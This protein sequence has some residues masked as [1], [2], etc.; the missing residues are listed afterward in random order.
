MASSRK[1]KTFKRRKFKG[2]GKKDKKDAFHDLEYVVP[3]L[4]RNQRFR[5]FETQIDNVLGQNP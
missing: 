4:S 5:K 1:R 2:K 3:D